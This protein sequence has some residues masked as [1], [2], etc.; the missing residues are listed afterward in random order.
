MLVNV[1]LTTFVLFLTVLLGFEAMAQSVTPAILQVY[2][3]EQGNNPVP[4]YDLL[5]RP[6]SV[7]PSSEFIVKTDNNGYWSDTVD[8][9]EDPTDPGFWDYSVMVLDSF[10]YGPGAYRSRLGTIIKPPYSLLD[11]LKF[12]LSAP[13]KAAD[14]CGS[15][16]VRADSAVN[17]PMLIYFRNDLNRLKVG[18]TWTYGDGDTGHAPNSYHRY[19][20]PGKYYFC[21]YTDSCG[22]VCDSV[23]VPMNGKGVGIVEES[24]ALDF[25]LYP[26]PANNVINIHADNEGVEI[27]EILI[28]DLSG[29]R[30]CRSNDK[31]KLNKD[32]VQLDIDKL[33]TGVYIVTIQT[34]NGFTHTHKMVKK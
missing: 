2:L 12:S 20:V 7:D 1:K 29:N 19:K 31:G 8:L 3:S 13:I 22:P 26:N 25:K 18:T 24:Y 15:Y 9:Y 16:Q 27:K 33:K 6:S 17:D 14:N 11:T 28:Y 23:T 4:G 21:H 5:I 30:L 32:R 10:S 34:E